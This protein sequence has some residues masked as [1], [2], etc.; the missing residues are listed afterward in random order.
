MPAPPPR[1]TNPLA[2]GFEIREIFSQ[3]YQLL[4]VS[5]VND[6]SHMKLWELWMAMPPAKGEKTTAE[7]LIQQAILD[8]IYRWT[9]TANTTNNQSLDIEFY[10]RA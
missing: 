1:T 8:I 9:D 3:V 5:N 4:S 7:Y 10:E 2:N 6:I